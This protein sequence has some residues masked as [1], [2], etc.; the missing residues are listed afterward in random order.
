M[1]PTLCFRRSTDDTIHHGTAGHD[2]ACYREK[3]FPTLSG[4]RKYHH[5]DVL[6][7][8]KWGL[9]KPCHNHPREAGNSALLPK[10]SQPFTE[11]AKT[12]AGSQG[13]KKV[14]GKLFYLE[15][16]HDGYEIISVEEPV[17]KLPKYSPDKSD[18]TSSA[19]NKAS[20]QNKPTV[21]A[22]ITFPIAEQE[23]IERLEMLVVKNDKVRKSYVDFLM[24]KKGSMSIVQFMPSV[25]ADEALESYNYNGSNTLGKMK[26]PMRGY[27][28]FSN[29]FLDAYASEGLDQ[30][31]LAAQMAA[32]IKQCRNRMRQRTFRAKKSIK[33]MLNQ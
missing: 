9:Q 19:S 15:A 6:S 1:K 2:A 32:A 7:E 33:K 23:D 14:S 31:E 28:I 18:R 22:G 17:V 13:I 27:E 4:P 30:T 29:C 3:L 5:L 8:K 25:F 20:A 12:R 26:L 16:E 24:R 21:I 11:N 10:R